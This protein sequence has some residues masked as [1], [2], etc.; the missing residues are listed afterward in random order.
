MVYLKSCFKGAI[1]LLAM[2]SQVILAQD[3]E[4]VLFLDPTEVLGASKYQQ[5]I[6]QAPAAVTVITATEIEDYGYETLG[7]ILES[8]PGFYYYHTRRNGVLGVRGFPRQSGYV[9]H[10]LFLIDGQPLNDG[11][12]GGM[13]L[14]EAAV[15]DV[16]QIERLEIIRGPGSSLYGANA[17]F[18]VINILTKRGRD[19][20]GIKGSLEYG[21]FEKARARLTV[22]RKVDTHREWLLAATGFDLGG[23][24]HLYYSDFDRPETNNGIVEDFGGQN[25]HAIRFKLRHGSW[26]LSAGHR[27]REQDLPSIPPKVV[28]NSR[29]NRADYEATFANLSF[30]RHVGQ[31]EIKF[32]ASWS[33]AREDLS[34]LLLP[35]DNI[36]PGFV[37][38][39]SWRGNRLTLQFEWYRRWN[40]VTLISGAENTRHFDIDLMNE[41][42]GLAVLHDSEHDIDNLGLYL[43][44][45]IIQGPW[46]FNLG[47]RRDDYDTFG[48]NWAPRLAVIR[49][50]PGDGSLK[51]LYGEAFR[52][53]NA[54]ENYF[55][56]SAGL[57]PNR[58]LTPEKIESIELV[59]EQIIAGFLNSRVSLFRNNVEDLI[60]LTFIPDFQVF[61]QENSQSYRIQ[62]IE[63]EL[64]A[65]FK[66]GMAAFFGYTYHEDKEYHLPTVRA[67]APHHVGKAGFR[68]NPTDS[69]W[70]VSSTWSYYGSRAT[71]QGK[72]L[73]EETIGRAKVSYKPRKDMSFAVVIE[74][75]LDRQIHQPTP[76]DI[77]QDAI[78]LDGRTFRF[79]FSFER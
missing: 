28:F 14:D 69:P 60:A 64:Q 9:Q 57:L 79:V 41:I 37:N 4:D 65:Q 16:S 55:E 42:E 17:F 67:N 54:F 22:G 1:C 21:S 35:T 33:Q 68:Y 30:D 77:A 11:V 20:Q 32:Q 40:N 44:S 23:D 26:Q 10:V 38:T 62:G 15:I 74:N 56:T 36:P 18:G 31:S 7:D 51:L 3:A 61:R 53:P 76:S 49:S 70:G 63:A 2:A 50:L 5:Q 8:V 24:D 52:A 72:I 25:S 48:S 73:G 6:S 45:E 46:T 75:I 12:S 27:F 43:Q 66:A 47:I 78:L 59:W 71:L 19:I 39:T 58:N 29:E 34:F 13:E